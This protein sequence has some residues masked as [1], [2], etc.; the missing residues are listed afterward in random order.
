MKQSFFLHLLREGSIL[1]D[2][3]KL[4]PPNYLPLSYSPNLIAKI[5]SALVQQVSTVM[6][7][8]GMLMTL[9]KIRDT[10]LILTLKRNSSKI[11]TDFSYRVDSGKKSIK[12]L[13]SP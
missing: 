5:Y 13:I 1:K 9:P 8:L 11:V 4:N 10:S 12:N 2:S 6:M 3:L 7:S